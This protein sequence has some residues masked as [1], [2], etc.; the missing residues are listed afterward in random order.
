MI[1]RTLPFLFLAALFV[2][3]SAAAKERAEDPLRV[4]IRAGV[5]THGPGEHDHPRFL[6]DWSVILAERGAEVAGAQRFPT[7]EELDA[8]D[9]MILYAAEGGSIHGEERARLDAFLARGGGLVVLHDAVC[10][11]APHWFK[12]VVG[13]A[14]EHGHAKWYTGEVGLYFP[15]REHPVMRGVP[16]SF[17]IT[18]ELY[19]FERDPSGPDIKVLAIGRSLETGEEYPVVWTVARDEGR[20]TCI[21]LGHDGKAH[22]LPAFK[23]LLKNSAA[24]A[25]REGGE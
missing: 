12:G 19:R 14:W 3:T 1:Q 17:R 15:D 16:A 25:A 24:W 21:T 8:T 7:A 5:K 11:D 20:T 23:Q 6:E 18:D 9:V 4:F 22:E 2:S 10:G 13:G